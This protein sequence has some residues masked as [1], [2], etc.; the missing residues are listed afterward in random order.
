M[1]PPAVEGRGTEEVKNQRRE[2]GALKVG[3]VGFTIEF[4]RPGGWRAFHR[5]SGKCAGALAQ[6][7]ALR[8]RRKNPITSLM[9]DIA[10]GTLREG[11]PQRE[12]HV[13]HRRDQG[14]G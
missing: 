3:E 14:H 5:N 8:S 11:H 13:G 1:N 4:G 12:G 6:G 7:G 9:S 2:R 10:T